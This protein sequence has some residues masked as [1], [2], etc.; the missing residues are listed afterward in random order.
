MAE[1]YGVHNVENLCDELE[2]I[3]SEIIRYLSANIEGNLQSLI[4][5]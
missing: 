1:S 2:L 3:I 5:P 4:K